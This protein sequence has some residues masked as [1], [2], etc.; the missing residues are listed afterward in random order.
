[1]AQHGH[2]V[3]GFTVHVPH[4]LAQTDY[5][6]AAEALRQVASLARCSCRWPRCRG[7]RR[8]ERKIKEQVDAS[9]EVAQWWRH[10]SASTM[11]SSQPR[12]TNRC[13]PAT[14][15]CSAATSSVASSSVF[16]PKQAGERK[17]FQ[18]GDSD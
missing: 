1:M 16:S 14:R 10:W 15:I 18:D 8:G 12:R 7:G 9:T 2:E 4:Y 5:P 3:V 11:P 13:W 17:G 6:A